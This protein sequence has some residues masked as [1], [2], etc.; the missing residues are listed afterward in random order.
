MEDLKQ[1]ITAYPKSS[2][3]CCHH[4]N[5]VVV[6]RNIDA[7]VTG[8]DGEIIDHRELESSAIGRCV[9]CGNEFHMVHIVNG[10]RPLTDFG[11]FL[12]NNLLLKEEPCELDDVK[13]PMYCG[14]E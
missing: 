9:N 5:F 12:Y 8:R 10:F 2:C 4:N 1:M 7:Y 3:P 14:D 6:E 13:N 11:L